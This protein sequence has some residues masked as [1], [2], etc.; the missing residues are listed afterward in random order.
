MEVFAVIV[1]A[2][3]ILFII[4]VICGQYASSIG[5]SYW[6][7]F[8]IACFLSFITLFVLLTLPDLSDAEDEEKEL[9]DNRNH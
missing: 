4:P 7:W 1:A 9:P 3:F 8:T 2:F 6:V 5:R